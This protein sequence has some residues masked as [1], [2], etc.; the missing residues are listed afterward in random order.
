MKQIIKSIPKVDGLGLIKGKPAYTRDLIPQNALVV[1]VLRSPHPFAR[2]KNINTEKAESLPGVECVLTYK[3]VPRNIVTRAGQ[4]YPEPSP[5]DKFILDEYVRYVG[6]EVAAV[7]AVDENLA[8]EA[9]KLIEVEY[10]VLE[11]VLDF[12]KAVDNPSVIHPEPEAHEMFPIG[13]DKKRNIAAE[14]HMGFG[15]IEETL[16]KCD[17]VLKDTF[18][19]QAQ[20]HMALETHSSFAY[21]D[22][23]GRLTIVSSTQVPYH[24]RRIVAHALDLK[25][26]DVRVIKPRVGGGYGGKQ[27]IHGEFLVSLVA[28]RT[29][30]PARLIFTR[31]EVFESSFSRHAMKFNMTVGADKE[32]NLKAV[33]MELLSD[34]GAFGEHALTVFMLAAAKTLP[35]YN[36]I[37]AVKFGGKVV[38][39]NHTPAGAYRGY[40]ALQGNF[41][42]ESMLDQIAHK[43][44]MDPMELRKK[45]MIKEGESSPIFK[46]MG[47]GTEGID[48]TIESCKLD[49]CVKRGAELSKWKEKFPRQQVSKNKVRGIGCALAMQGSGIAY[50]DMASAVLKLNDGGFFNLT[51]GATDLGT[52]SDT[53]LAQIA[54][55]AL[56]ISSDK[57]KVYSSDTDLT[58]F[59]CGAYASKTTYV[60]GNAVLRTAQKMKERIREEGARKFNVPIEQVEFDGEYVKTVD[61]KE[62][63]SLV[64][65]SSELYYNSEQKQLLVSDSF[66][67]KVAPPPYMIGIAEVEVDLETGKYELLDYTGVVD[68][69]TTINPNLCRIQV[70]GGLVQGIG[71]AMFEDV[72]YSQSGKMSTNNLMQYKVPTRKDINK[73]T[74]EFADSYE[75]TGPYGAKSVGEMG[76]D[77]PLAA[78][79]N[80]VYNATGVRIT[81]LPITP[82]KVLMG[83]KKLNK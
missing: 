72:R 45:N 47:E 31:K 69:G 49:Y 39:T 74:V 38:Y 11:P 78:I 18:Y 50:I 75:P 48:M 63:I 70:E 16:S 42:V 27:Q 71:M 53:I 37:E 57:I 79:A 19:T 33:N 43:I 20:A 73:L 56:G 83:L 4:G 17:V 28:L 59:D 67:P 61:G 81:T 10:E 29:G 68:C 46:I 5:H 7:A 77:T 44:N 55:E 58:P 25:I 22:F 6:D 12:E 52:G 76:I 32:G 34:T 21:V 24:I 60:S 36:K 30:K 41:A 35:L 9:L 15:D 13:F 82:E 62:S 64:D 1:K 80:A 2:I 65:F 14:Y 54:A 3:N 23:Y 51:I 40:G 26:E 8:E 66:V